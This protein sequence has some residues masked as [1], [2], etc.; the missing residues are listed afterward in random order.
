MP[1]GLCELIYWTT[2]VHTQQAVLFV[3]APWAYPIFSHTQQECIPVGC[4]QSAAVAADREVSARRGGGCLTRVCLPRG[5]LSWGCLPWG[6]CASGVSAWG[7]SAQEGVSQG[8]S[9]GGCL[10]GRGSTQG[11]VWKTP[12]LPCE[13]NDW[14]TGMKTLPCRNY[15]TD[16]KKFAVMALMPT[17]YSHI[18]TI[19]FII[20]TLRY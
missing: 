1:T 16:G 17:L 6:V 4:V 2:Q 11:I 18:V 20:C 15:V 10:P 19:F 7:L 14:Q 13:Q 8:V 5:C 12:P 3:Y 9:T